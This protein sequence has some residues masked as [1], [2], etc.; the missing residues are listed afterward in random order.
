MFKVCL[1]FWKFSLSVKSGFAVVPTDSASFCDLSFFYKFF[2]FDH[3]VS[4]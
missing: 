2:S 3:T 4:V 1:S